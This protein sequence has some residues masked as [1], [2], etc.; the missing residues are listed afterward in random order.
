MSFMSRWDDNRT[1]SNKF[2]HC[3]WWWCTT[4]V[5]GTVPLLDYND[6]PLL[7]K[8][9]K[10]VDKLLVVGYYFTVKASLCP[11][12][13]QS[14][15]S[16]SSTD[17]T[18]NRCRCHCSLLHCHSTKKTSEMIG[19]QLKSAFNTRK[20]EVIL[21]PLSSRRNT[22]PERS[23]FCIHNHLREGRKHLSFVYSFDD[24]VI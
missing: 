24:N 21:L 12:V 16:L 18:L 17:S 23:I 11:A 8:I 14:C 1:R 22:S 4:G 6:T 7:S 15:E 2:L 3:R 19:I 5:G 9:I 20:D 13:P 10:T